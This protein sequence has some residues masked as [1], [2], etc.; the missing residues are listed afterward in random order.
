MDDLLIENKCEQLKTT[1]TP[2]EVSIKLEPQG[3]DK[4]VALRRYRWL[5]DKLIYLTRIRQISHFIEV[6][7]K[8]G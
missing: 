8:C 5:V 4:L 7:V 3:R 2:L 1:N 6:S